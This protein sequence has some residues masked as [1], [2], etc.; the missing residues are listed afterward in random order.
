MWFRK[1]TR[2]TWRRGTSIGTTAIY[3]NLYIRPVRKGEAVPARAVPEEGRCNRDL[4]DEDVFNECLDGIR[5]TGT[6]WLPLANM[7]N[8]CP[9]KVDL[10]G[11][12]KT[13]MGD[14][15]VGFLTGADTDRF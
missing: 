14:I 8:P 1:R 5:R 9:A 11:K 7:F 10:A 12:G 6:L 13:R 2:P 4:T 3:N 15:S